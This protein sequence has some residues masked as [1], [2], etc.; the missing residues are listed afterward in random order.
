MPIADYS[1][2][3]TM[4]QNCMPSYQLARAAR[5]LRWSDARISGPFDW[6]GISIDQGISAIETKFR[7]FF[8]PS[9]VFIGDHDDAFA[10]EC[11]LATVKQRAA[12]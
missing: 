9:R 5:R 8:D 1:Y 2:V 10:L 7:Q 3:V 4:G 11:T 6:F 12:R